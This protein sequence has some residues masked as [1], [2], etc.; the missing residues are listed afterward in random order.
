MISVFDRIQT[1]LLSPL[2]TLLSSKRLF[3]NWKR[4]EIQI[5]NLI[6]HDSISL[7][8]VVSKLAFGS[9]LDLLQKVTGTVFCIRIA[10]PR[11]N[12]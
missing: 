10:V 2:T 9:A 6:V 11:F 7:K 12:T 4:F 3:Q 5:N 8:K 1:F